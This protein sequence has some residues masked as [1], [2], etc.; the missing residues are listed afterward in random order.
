VRQQC[1]AVR[2]QLP[3]F[4]SRFGC[5]AEAGAGDGEAATL[6]A[7]MQAAGVPNSAWV[8]G[9]KHGT[10]FVR[11]AE[12]AAA[13]EAAAAAVEAAAVL[14]RARAAVTVQAHVRGWRG[15]VCA[16]SR[17]LQR[18]QQ[19]AA[20]KAKAAR[21][22]AAAEAAK[23]EAAAA[24]AVA[25]EQAEKT[26]APPS[27]LSR[28][29][30]LKRADSHAS[31]CEGHGTVA[32]S[33]PPPPKRLSLTRAG[34]PPQPPASP[35]DI[36]TAPT[37]AAPAAA[38]PM[39]GCSGW[40]SK[41]TRS[42]W[43]RLGAPAA[44]GRLWV[45]AAGRQLDLYTDPSLREWKCSMTLDSAT[46][47]TAVVP[48]EH[49]VDLPDAAAVDQCVLSAVHA[50]FIARPACRPTHTTRI[51]GSS[52]IQPSEGGVSLYLGEQSTDCAREGGVCD[53]AALKGEPLARETASKTDERPFSLS[54]LDA[55]SAPRTS[56]PS[57]TA[58]WHTSYRGPNPP[59]ES[60]WRVGILD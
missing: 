23:K 49:D 40:L 26:A 54:Q 33:P 42:R 11:T 35:G 47:V 3:D 6:Q 45:T 27:A 2:W 4:L 34:E 50:P 10:V 37:K 38:L 1:H 51:R 13:V 36:V 48:L 56:T 17:R 53:T 19:T 20:A 57:P 7:V 43:A 52:D 18:E 32:L 14:R 5:L 28:Q 46:L 24:A 31:H 55:S 30:S 16:A 25:A 21:A 8:Q 44:W 9:A 15:R 22:A 29:A 60:L 39:E 58:L 41:Q 59:R 12:A